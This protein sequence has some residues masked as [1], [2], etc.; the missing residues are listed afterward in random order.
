MI[1]LKNILSHL[2]ENKIKELEIITE[3]ITATG[4]AE[5]IVL[6]G[7]YAR[8]DY[9]EERGK[10]RGKKSDYDI[11]VIISD[12][13]NDTKNKLRN[14]LNRKFKDISVPVQ[15]IVEKE[16]YVNSNLREKQYFFTDVKREGKILFDTK[17]HKLEEPKELT[18]TRRREIAEA[19]FQMWFNKGKGFFID[20]EN[21]INRNDFGL[22]SFYT[23]QAVEMCYTAIEMVLTHYN[24]YEHNLET[25]RER[26]IKF[27]SRIKEVLPYET[28]EQIELFDYLNFAYIGGRYRSE[29]DFPISKEQLDYWSEEAQKLLGLTEQIC[30]E[31]IETLKEIEKNSR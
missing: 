28:E 26:I 5:I 1:D 9:K 15:L 24:P 21:A 19:D 23:Q 13:D 22:A 27:D 25:L 3:R 7:S 12:C 17:K 6:Y 10:H 2:P 18:P 16:Y 31:K 20:K 11:L 8:G 29:E 4:K 14:E 30:N